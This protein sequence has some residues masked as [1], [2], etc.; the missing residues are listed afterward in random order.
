MVK[1]MKNNEEKE[2]ATQL[3]IKA[4]IIKLPSVV[5]QLSGLGVEDNVHIK[6]KKGKIVVEKN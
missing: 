6:M 2:I 3:D 1:D 5:T 4:G